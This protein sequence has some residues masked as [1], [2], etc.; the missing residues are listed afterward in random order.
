[1]G[2]ENLPSGVLEVK[3]PGAGAILVDNLCSSFTAAAP[4]THEEDASIGVK[5]TWM[6]ATIIQ[7]ALGHSLPWA[8]GK[9]DTAPSD[10][11][12]NIASTGSQTRLS[13]VISSLRQALNLA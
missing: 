11:T 10:V 9:F 12:L 1:M 13:V 6:E 5:P 7:E 4:T 3:W 2:D 8:T